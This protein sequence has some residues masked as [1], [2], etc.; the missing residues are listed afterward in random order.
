MH[1]SPAIFGTTA[2]ACSA[3]LQQ[4]QLMLMLDSKG[5][6]VIKTTTA[7]NIMKTV[8]EEGEG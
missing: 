1:N 4:I 3:I 8:E 5:S 7:R 6:K 2:N